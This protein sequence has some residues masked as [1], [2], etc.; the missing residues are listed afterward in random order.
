MITIRAGETAETGKNN[1]VSGKLSSAWNEENLL[2]A[3]FKNFNGYVTNA[4][5]FQH[6]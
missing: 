3:R 5:H 4:L 6:F 2:L 1:F